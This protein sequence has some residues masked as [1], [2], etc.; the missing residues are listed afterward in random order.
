MSIFDIEANGLLDT[1]TKIH[2]LSYYK[3]GKVY[4]L[5]DYED[6]KSWV[7]D[8][9]ILIGHNIIA[10]DIP[11]LEKILGITITAKLY[12][13]LAI[14]WVLNYDRPKHGLES[15]GEE[16]GVPK[17]VVTDWQNLSIEEYVHRCEE[18]VKI[19]QR[20]WDNSIKELLLIYNHDKKELDRYLQYLTFKMKCAV[21]A[22]EEGWDCDID[23]INN[24]LDTLYSLQE[25]K[26]KELKEVM[27]KVSKYKTKTKP[28]VMYKKDGTFSVAGENWYILTEGKIDVEKIEVFDRYEEPNPKSDPQIK[29]WL[30]SLGWKPNIYKYEKKDGKE[31]KIPQVRQEGELTESVRELIEEHPS[32]EILDGFTIINH[33]I[34]FFEALKRGYKDGKVRA[35]ISGFTNTLRFRHKEPLANIPGVDKPWGKEIR[36]CLTASQGH[37]LCG[38]DMVSLESTTKRHYMYP[39]DPE[40]VEE[41][42]KPGFD[43]HLD[44][45]KH[46]GAVTQKQIELYNQTGD[47]EV[48][49]IRKA[50]KTTNYSAIYGVGPP[51]LSRELGCSLHKATQ[52]LEAYWSRNHAVKKF[53]ATCETK[54]VKGK[55]WVYN[56][57]SKF[58]YSLRA[59]KDIF[60]TVNQSTGVYCFDTW[61]YFYL[62]E[63]PNIIGQFHDESIN[64]LKETEQEIHRQTLL[65]AIKKTND[66][67]KLNVELK[68][69][70]KFGYT[71]AEIH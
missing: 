8:Q 30:F 2:C 62:Q 19:N 46:A 48:K 56:P 20:L 57:V 5:T 31:K 54:L 39:F 14:S 37:I 21:K 33:R 59:E 18:D 11:T 66:K 47:K 6:I 71:Y 52:L 41:M 36:G 67:L 26:I 45:A 12:D 42:S 65:R 63:R 25:Q 64:K 4:S 1:V 7:L 23:S 10:Y 69:D 32:V 60:S 38:A 22:Y 34:G 44:L 16:Y 9:K 3:D 40:Y 27:P 24:S 68:I 49:K 28:K 29:D 58:W 15:Y 55:L 61:L 50:Y 70:I 43:E 35:D 53:V 13:T 51:K 17:P